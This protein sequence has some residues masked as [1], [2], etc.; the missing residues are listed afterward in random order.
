M[1]S[2]GTEEPRK[3]RCVWVLA[4]SPVWTSPERLRDL[5]D[6]D[7]V[8][9]ADGGSTLAARL[10]LVPDLVIGDLDSSDPGLVRELEAERVKFDRFQHETKLET[11]TELAVLAALAW[12]P[13]T[14]LVLGAIGGRLD[15]SVANLLLLTHP[16]LVTH[17]V[18]L[19]DGKQVALLAKPGRWNEIPASEGDTVSLLPVGGEATGAV[20]SDLLYPLNSETL[21]EGR[22]RG[23]SNQVTGP[24]PRV[25]YEQGL[26]MVIVVRTGRTREETNGTDKY[27]PR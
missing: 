3:V 1:E 26:L 4:A 8:I 17:D 20:T 15:H 2:Q 14:I 24:Q 5:P 22:G 25:F 27:E 13:D 21:L 7:V 11:D 12:Q 23:V 6:P 10:G 18:R 19:V 9:A 16:Q